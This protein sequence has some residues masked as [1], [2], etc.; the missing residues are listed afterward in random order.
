MRRSVLASYLSQGYVTL[1]SILM[2]PWY[3]RYLGAE[4]YGL[5]GVFA[6][7]QAWFMLLDIGLT[8]TLARETARFH[9][10]ALS[11]ADYRSLVRVLELAFLAMAVLIAAGLFLG[12]GSLARNWLKV[13][14]ISLA[15]VER[16]LQIMALIVAL[17]WMCGL[18]RSIVTGAERLVWLAQNLGAGISAAATADR[19]ESR[20]QTGGPSLPG[21][22]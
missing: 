16:A 7:L 2:V 15:E 4:A 14:E 21:H 13:S 20:H 5:V 1:V 12:S 11:S 6:M 10:H 9:G 22:H 18:Y 19:D 8:P 3:L 17:R